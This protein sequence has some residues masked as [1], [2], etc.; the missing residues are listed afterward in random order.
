VDAAQNKP[1]E[2]SRKQ[3]KKEFKAQRIKEEEEKKATEQPA[4]EE[5]TEA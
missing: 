3:M 1:N 2:K 4:S 5:K